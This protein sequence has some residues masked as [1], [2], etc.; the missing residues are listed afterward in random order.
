MKWIAAI[1]REILGLF[2]DDGVFAG[3]VFLCLLAAWAVL[4]RID[5]PAGWKGAILFLALAL[6]LVESV[7]RRAHRR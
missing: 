7:R 5:I 3:S 6:I 1:L 2:V 4:P